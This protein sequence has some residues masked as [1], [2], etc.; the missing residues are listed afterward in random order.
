MKMNLPLAYFPYNTQTSYIWR[1]GM[2][3]RVKL[4]DVSL[5]ILFTAQFEQKA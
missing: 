2:T 1:F 5:V 3:E 4:Q